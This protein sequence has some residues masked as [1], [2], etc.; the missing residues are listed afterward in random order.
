MPS[1][2]FQWLRP[3][4]ASLTP[5]WTAVEGEQKVLLEWRQNYC[6]L[7]KVF[8]LQRRWKLQLVP[9]RPRCSLKSPTNEINLELAGLGMFTQTHGKVWDTLLLLNRRMNSQKYIKQPHEWIKSENKIN[10]IG[11]F[12]VCFLVSDEG[13]N[14]II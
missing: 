4:C 12:T 2:Q 11:G 9:F 13:R 7:K 5:H 14:S 10:V 1:Q 3:L 8:L 6:F